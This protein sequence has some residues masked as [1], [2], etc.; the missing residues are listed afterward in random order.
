MI[1]ALGTIVKLLLQVN[2]SNLASSPS[3]AMAVKDFDSKNPWHLVLAGLN[4]FD[5]WQV[6]VLA[7]GL[8]R[9]ASVSFARAGFAVFGFW[10]IFSSVMIAYAAGVQRLF[11]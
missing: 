4:V 2:F 1:G 11:G 9:L 7:L 5:L 6:V 8:A 10:V 3:L